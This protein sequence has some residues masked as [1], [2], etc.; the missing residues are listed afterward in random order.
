M[1]YWVGS[2]TKTG[3]ASTAV[4]ALEHALI[5][6]FRCLGKVPGRFL[7]RSDNGLVFTSR[8]YIAL[9]KSYGL[10]QE[11]ITPHCPQQNRMMECLI[12]T[13]KEQCVHRY[14]FES[15]QH[16]NWMLSDWIPFYNEARPHQAL[17][18]KI[19]A[20]AYALSL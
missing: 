13:I 17:G 5:N 9:V 15:L 10:Q 18:M 1:N 8:K 3:K 12:R 16:A 20:E 7:L 19:P 2:F 4:S 6:R 11:F 14:R